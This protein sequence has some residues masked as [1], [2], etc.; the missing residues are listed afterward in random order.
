MWEEIK[1]KSY[2]KYDPFKSQLFLWIGV[3]GEVPSP[4]FRLLLSLKEV[5][6][7]LGVELR[8]G[9]YLPAWMREDLGSIPSTLCK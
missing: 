1:I 4:L 6:M 2:G 8:Q 9:L 7:G 3:H 5:H